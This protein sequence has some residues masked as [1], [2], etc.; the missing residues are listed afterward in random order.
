M[1]NSI[2]LTKLL[3]E[4]NL[5]KSGVSISAKIP[6]KGFG[7]IAMTAQ[8]NGIVLNFKEDGFV[9]VYEGGKQQY[10]P[11]ENL[12]AIEGMDISRF[13]QAYRIKTKK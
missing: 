11:Y 4:K 13:A 8:K 12:I 2:S 3:A 7:N 1:N 5:L 9:A 6:V 10:T